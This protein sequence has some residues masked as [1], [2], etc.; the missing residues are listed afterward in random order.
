MQEGDRDLAEGTMAALGYSLLVQSQQLI[1]LPKSEPAT[2]RTVPA[3]ASLLAVR[4][5]KECYVLVSVLQVVAASS[6]DPV[7][8]K[9]PGTPGTGTPARTQLSVP[10]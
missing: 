5:S 2:S 3:F 7:P 6:P 9:V 10:A 1:A 8:M 4:R